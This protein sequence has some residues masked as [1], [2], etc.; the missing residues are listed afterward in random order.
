MKPAAVSQL[1]LGIEKSREPDRNFNKGGRSFYFFDFDDNIACLSTPII[2]FH[3]QTGRPVELSSQQFAE[4]SES[5]G[6]YGPVQDFQLDFDDHSGSFQ[7]F[8]DKSFKVIDRLLGK[9]QT[10]LKDLESALVKKDF[11][12]QGPSWSCFHHAV[13][14]Q[15]P[16]SLITA[17]GHAPETMQAG[18]ELMVYYGYLPHVPNYLSVFPVSHPPTM[19]Q[20]KDEGQAPDIAQLKQAAIR[21]SVETALQ[22]YGNNPHHRFGMSDDDPKNVRLIFDEMTRL[23]RQYTEM[24]FFVISTHQGQFVKREIFLDSENRP[25]LQAQEQLSLF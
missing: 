25:Q 3:K 2:L 19:N 21:K 16:V 17:R 5:I 23:K 12:W 6:K 1:S 11:I 9:Q 24:S 8:R 14:N 15:R 18:M 22:Q 7:Y 13:Y 4:V 20:L 10:F